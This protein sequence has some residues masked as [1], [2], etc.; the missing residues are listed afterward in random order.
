MNVDNT[1][2]FKKVRYKVNVP[3]GFHKELIFS[4]QLSEI[5][6]IYPDSSIIYLSDKI[7]SGSYTNWKNLQK[8][9]ENYFLQFQ[10]S[11]S[12]VL[13]GQE[14]GLHWEERKLDLVIV[15]FLN[16]PQAKLL[17]F[18]TAISTLRR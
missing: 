9:D 8:Q 17:E 6:L 4:D 16:V 13:D 1:W 2:S 11:D 3:S 5:Q 12:L 18:R 14:R 10:E 15:G 7:N